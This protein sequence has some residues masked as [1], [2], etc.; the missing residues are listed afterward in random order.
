[1]DTSGN[2]MLLEQLNVLAS[3]VVSLTAENKALQSKK[4]EVTASNAD[5]SPPLRSLLQQADRICA[6]VDDGVGR[7]PLNETGDAVLLS[8]SQQRAIFDRIAA[9]RAASISET[10][11]LCQEIAQL[12][13]QNMLLIT[14]VE[15]LHEERSS[16]TAVTAAAAMEREHVVRLREEKRALERKCDDMR[17][18][19][20]E[21]EGLLADLQYVES[22]KETL[23]SLT[24]RQ[25]EEIDRLVGEVEGLRARLLLS[26]AQPSSY[27]SAR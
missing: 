21:V 3:R 12:R 5:L 25:Q 1:M 9:F 20:R 4:H 18:Q 24:L 16:M 14:E 26:A 10:A 23:E 11:G 7:A 13:Q 19:I 8:A 15:E 2:A 27:A 22:E 17:S 6:A